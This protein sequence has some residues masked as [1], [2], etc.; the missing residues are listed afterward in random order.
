LQ[1][2]STTVRHPSGAAVSAAFATIVAAVSQ[3]ARTLRSLSSAVVHHVKPSVAVHCSSEVSFFDPPRVRSLSTPLRVT[4]AHLVNLRPACDA[5]I[6]NC[7]S[8]S[9]SDFL[10]HGHAND[11]SLL[12]AADIAADGVVR[13][14]SK[15]Q[16]WMDVPT[17]HTNHL[18]SAAVAHRVVTS[19]S[20]QDQQAV[21][22]VALVSGRCSVLCASDDNGPV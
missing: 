17:Q 21:H 14:R 18:Q 2:F 7:L 8:C 10:G 3:S 12:C 16:C 15:T 1:P 5:A 19:A 13:P 11:P 4:F 22:L 9:S 6:D 20:I